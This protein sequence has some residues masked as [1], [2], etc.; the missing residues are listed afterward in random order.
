MISAAREVAKL[1]EKFFKGVGEKRERERKT[2]DK[3]TIRY[4]FDGSGTHKHDRS[5]KRS[6]HGDN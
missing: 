6:E 3:K 5:T 4:S 2:K 1:S